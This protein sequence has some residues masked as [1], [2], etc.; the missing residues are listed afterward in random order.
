MKNQAKQ[1]PTSTL[2]LPLRP[3]VAD[4][5]WKCKAVLAGEEDLKVLADCAQRATV[6]VVVLAPS[7][8]GG[9]GAEGEGSHAHL[10]KLVWHLLGQK[11][12]HIRYW[13]VVG[14]GGVGGQGARLG[15]GAV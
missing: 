3:Q 8:G 2:R 12:V 9:A 5:G 14:W 4:Q 13:A 6:I 7:H 10:E 15:G 11:K 1:R